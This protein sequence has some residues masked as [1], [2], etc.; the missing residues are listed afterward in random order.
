MMSLAIG[1]PLLEMM[2]EIK[3]GT[4]PQAILGKQAG[5]RL[6]SMD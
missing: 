3:A 2:R 5:G 4:S 1:F 6:L